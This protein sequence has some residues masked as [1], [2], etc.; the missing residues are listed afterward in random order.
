MICIRDKIGGEAGLKK[1]IG[2][3]AK[4]ARKRILIVDDEEAVARMMAEAL[5]ADGEWMTFRYVPGEGDAELVIRR[6]DRDTGES[7]EF[8]WDFRNRLIEV[9]DRDGSGEIRYSRVTGKVSIPD[10]KS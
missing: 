1:E 3:P 5:T 2:M 8:S 10:D 4:G 6:T 9:V 7:R